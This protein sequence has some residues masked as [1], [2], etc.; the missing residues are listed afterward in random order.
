MS[1]CLLCQGSGLVSQGPGPEHP[2]SLPHL[3][4]NGTIDFPEFLTMMARKMKDTD[5]EEEIREAFRVFDKV[6]RPFPEWLWDSGREQNRW[7]PRMPCVT[8]VRTSRRP[9]PQCHPRCRLA[10]PPQEAPLPL[11]SVGD[12]TVPA[13][14]PP[15]KS[16]ANASSS[17]L[18]SVP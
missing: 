14:W 5:S 7:R 6:S 1:R 9:R 13:L 11:L 18:L 10:L 15:G 3:A 12:L 4:G 2:C 17:K 8:G 16:R